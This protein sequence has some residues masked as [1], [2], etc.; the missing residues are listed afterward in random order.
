MS[1]TPNFELKVS[2]RF[3]GSCVDVT[4][5]VLLDPTHLASLHV[6]KLV[7][8]W[9]FA[10]G[11]CTRTIRE[12][13]NWKRD[14][15]VCKMLALAGDLLLVGS[16]EKNQMEDEKRFNV[17]DVNKG[18]VVFDDRGTILAKDW[19]VARGKEARKAWFLWA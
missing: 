4:G 5:L 18:N 12:D 17:W 14:W 13:G 19:H 7:C 3:S 16:R 11:K 15:E 2:H 6:G 9:D 8:I 10:Q 1:K